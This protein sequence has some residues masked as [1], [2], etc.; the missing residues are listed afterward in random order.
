MLVDLYIGLPVTG[1]PLQLTVCRHHWWCSSLRLAARNS[2]T[3][4]FYV[5]SIDLLSPW[6]IAIDRPAIPEATNPI[7]CKL[8]RLLDTG[9]DSLLTRWYKDYGDRILPSSTAATRVWWCSHRTNA[10][11]GVPWGSPRHVQGH[12]TGAC[13]VLDV[14]VKLE[15]C[16]EIHME[17]ISRPTIIKDAKFKASESLL[18]PKKERPSS[19]SR[20]AIGFSRAFWQP[21]SA[22]TP[23][24]VLTWNRLTLTAST[25]V[26]RFISWQTPCP[27]ELY[28]TL[29]SHSQSLGWY[30]D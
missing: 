21:A 12:S 2:S 30:P 25:P 20:S 14:S 9:P 13:S 3:I 23:L 15:S 24:Q 17:I 27:F 6:N 4:S 1:A 7:P 22:T 26:P 18:Q 10:S 16:F 28:G 8:V 19:A 5:R 29:W 11:H